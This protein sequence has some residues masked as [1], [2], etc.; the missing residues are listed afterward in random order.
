M[1]N[2]K[3]ENMWWEDNFGG[4]NFGTNNSNRGDLL[5]GELALVATYIFFNYFNDFLRISY[6]GSIQID[7][8]YFTCYK[9]KNIMARISAS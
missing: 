7:I 2:S 5:W 3:T 9:G 6:I 1:A 8:I 4:I